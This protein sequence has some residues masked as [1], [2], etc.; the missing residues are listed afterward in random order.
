M[1]A[2]R[3]LEE[4]RRDDWPRILGAAV[5]FGLISPSTA[6]DLLGLEPLAPEAG[7]CPGCG[8]FTQITCPD[9]GQD[10]CARCWACVTDG[11]G[12]VLESR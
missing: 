5:G 7:Q 2:F 8:C 1:R 6:R 3:H 9:C 12:P 11:C 10:A 4:Y